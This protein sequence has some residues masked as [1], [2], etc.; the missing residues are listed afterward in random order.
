MI[1]TMSS[2]KQANLVSVIVPVFNGEQFIADALDSIFAQSYTAIQVIVAD[3][4]ST[5]DTARIAQSYPDVAYEYQTNQGQAAAMNVGLKHARGD[6]LAFI[7][8]DDIWVPEKLSLQVEFLEKNPAVDMV[9]GRTQNFLDRKAELPARITKDI[10]PDIQALLILGSLL[11]RKR[12]FHKIG[13]FDPQYS[14]SKDV[15][16]FIRARENGVR[17]EIMP[18][19][20]LRR[21]L[22]TSNRSYQQVGRTADYLRT[23]KSLLD[24]KRAQTSDGDKGIATS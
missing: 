3:D 2:D 22:H 23:I 8:A 6:F 17:M 12:V 1:N 14:F 20:V 21:R 19:L 16:W 11:A 18:D 9:I 10:S 24:R 15:D 5:D 13:N 4:G 7:D